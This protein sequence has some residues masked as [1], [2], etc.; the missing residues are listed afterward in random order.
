MKS[1]LSFAL[2]VLLAAFSIAA[3]TT[4]TT[5]TLPAAPVAVAT[6][7]P[8]SPGIVV[9]GATSSS[10]I[11]I[12]GFLSLNSQPAPGAKHTTGGGFLLYPAANTTTGHP[13]YARM[14]IDV[15]PATN[16]KACLGTSFRFGAEQVLFSAG[17]FVT[18]AGA[19]IGVVVE[20]TATA[21]A[22]SFDV[23]EA[24]RFKDKA[25]F[26]NGAFISL[27]GQQNGNTGVVSKFEIG[28]F[29]TF[30]SN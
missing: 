28:F 2:V 11:A 5:T 12:G 1:F 19:D 7:A 14:S 9:P 25:K 21:G 6:P 8:L 17:Q 22:F 3:Q 16:C 24:Y 20:S 4:T 27:G 26:V 18:T 10:P 15:S 23:R 13:T 30:G 29:K